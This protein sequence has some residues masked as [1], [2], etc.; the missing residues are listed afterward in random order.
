MFCC[1]AARE[2]NGAIIGLYRRGRGILDITDGVAVCYQ[3]Y[4]MDV[5]EHPSAFNYPMHS[6][7]YLNVVNTWLRRYEIR[8]RSRRPSWPPAS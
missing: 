1:G 2:V 8:I 7:D 6:F 3:R 5:L 4:L